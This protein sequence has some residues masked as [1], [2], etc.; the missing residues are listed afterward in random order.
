M[1]KEEKKT[2]ITLA[3]KFSMKAEKSDSSVIIYKR[4]RASAA[5]RDLRIICILYIG[6]T[7]S[8]MGN[9]KNTSAL[10]CIFL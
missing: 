9:S 7:P 4:E 5:R 2:S 10:F 3:E 6:D 1:M 8:R